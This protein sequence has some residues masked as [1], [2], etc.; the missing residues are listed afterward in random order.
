MAEFVPMV[1]AAIAG[2]VVLGSMISL[3]NSWGA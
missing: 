1:S 3:F 2:A